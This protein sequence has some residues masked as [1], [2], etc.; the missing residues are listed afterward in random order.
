MCFVAVE[1]PWILLC[2]FFYENN[3]APA[4]FVTD[5]QS[6]LMGHVHTAAGDM[7]LGCSLKTR[8]SNARSG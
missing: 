5:V 2:E 1:R 4:T 8:N 7:A 3:I 6:G